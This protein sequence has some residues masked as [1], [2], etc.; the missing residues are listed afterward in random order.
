MRLPLDGLIAL[1]YKVLMQSDA[2][3]AAYR[4]ESGTIRRMLLVTTLITAAAAGFCVFFQAAK[5]PLFRDAHPFLEDPYDL[6]GALAVPVAFVAA[7][8]TCARA[9]RL[10]VDRTQAPKAR[11]I[12]RGNLVGLG[13]ILVTLA[14]DLIAVVLQPAQPSRWSSMLVAG[15]HALLAFA[16]VCRRHGTRVRP[17]ADARA[18]AAFVEGGGV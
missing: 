16:L 17:S 12:R 6:V 14:T 3:P 1:L 18:R 9:V 15:W 11:L 5:T 13:S 10:R 2:I 8:L 4:L 7:V